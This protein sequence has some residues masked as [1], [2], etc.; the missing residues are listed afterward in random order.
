MG[1][2][3]A[4]TQPPHHRQS[5]NASNPICRPT[6]KKHPTMTHTPDKPSETRVTALSDGLIPSEAV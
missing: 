3:V 2:R 1:F 4:E 5:G 6:T